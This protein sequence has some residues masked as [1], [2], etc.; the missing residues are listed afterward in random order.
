[1]A[2]TL[3]NSCDWSKAHYFLWDLFYF[4]ECP[5]HGLAHCASCTLNDASLALQ[6]DAELRRLALV[7]TLQQRQGA[8]AGMRVDLRARFDA[9][10]GQFP[11]G[12]FLLLLLGLLLGISRELLRAD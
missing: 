11:V 7:G 4:S 6:R 2:C 9:T 12:A 1:M 8:L 10:E 5:T 3:K